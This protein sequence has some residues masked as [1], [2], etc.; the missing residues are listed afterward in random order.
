MSGFGESSSHSLSSD[1]FKSWLKLNSYSSAS[2]L[3]GGLPD[4]RSLM[5]VVMMPS[6]IF[7]CEE[8]V[9]Q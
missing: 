4:L 1:V 7:E 5:T 3:P 8:F 2:G 6:P 9:I